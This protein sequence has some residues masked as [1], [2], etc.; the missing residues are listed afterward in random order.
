MMIFSSIHDNEKSLFIIKVE[1]NLTIPYCG[2]TNNID[3][4]EDQE[5][6][7]AS[8]VKLKGRWDPEDKSKTLRL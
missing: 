7:T 3:E 4:L 6:V 1:R 8:I 5:E 2:S